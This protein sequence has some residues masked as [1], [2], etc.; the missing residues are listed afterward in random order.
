MTPSRLEEIVKG[1]ELEDFPGIGDMVKN[2]AL[3][4]YFRARDKV[5][6]RLIAEKGESA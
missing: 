6:N 1:A 2:D 5:R 3:V 4:D